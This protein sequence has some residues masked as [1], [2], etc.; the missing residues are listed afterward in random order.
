MLKFKQTSLYALGVLKLNSY[1]FP[2]FYNYYKCTSSYPR[3][4][5]KSSKAV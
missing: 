4:N 5:M 3:K 1:Y 2:D